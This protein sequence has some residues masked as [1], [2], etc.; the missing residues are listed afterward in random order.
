[1]TT[2]VFV[3]SGVTLVLLFVLGGLQKKVK[4]LQVLPPQ[5]IAVVAGVLLGLAFNLGALN[6]GKF[7]IKVPSTLF[8]G[9]HTPHFAELLGRQDLW[10]AVIMGV[11]LLTMIDGVESLATAMAV[12]RIDPFHRRSDPNRVLLAMAISNIASSMVGGLTI[13]PGGVKSKVNVAAGGRTLWANYTN[14]VC[15]ILY[16]VVGYQLINLIPRGVLAAVLLYTGWKCVSRS[17]GDTWR[18]SAKN[19]WRFLPL[20]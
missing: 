16:I 15:L 9:I 4:L 2:S 12:D 14:A 8:E 10:Y 1:M 5:L 19:N 13:I 11:L 18:I 7:L 6:D 17:C 20:P 3:V